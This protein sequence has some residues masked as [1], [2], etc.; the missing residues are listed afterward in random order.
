MK[1]TF[2]GEAEADVLEAATYYAEHGGGGQAFL[3]EVERA[4]ELVRQFPF[5]GAELAPGLRRCRLDRFPYGIGY[6]ICADRIRVL[7]VM[8]LHRDPASWISRLRRRATP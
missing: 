3:A 2:L 4:T 7:A 5:S 6:E 1:V 8:H